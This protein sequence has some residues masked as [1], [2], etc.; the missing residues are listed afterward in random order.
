MANRWGFCL[1]EIEKLSDT[2]MLVD[3]DWERTINW[4]T[5]ATERAHIRAEKSIRNA[6]KI[7]YVG[8][9]LWVGGS[10]EPFSQNIDNNTIC[11]SR[12]SRQYRNNRQVHP[13]HMYLPKI[14]RYTWR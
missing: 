7:Q 5:L 4:H 11:R 3:D 13:Y 9:E 1:D 10:G 8:T 14:A 12:I 6:Y 2:A